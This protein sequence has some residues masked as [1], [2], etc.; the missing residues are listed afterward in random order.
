MSDS[1][2]LPVSDADLDGKERQYLLEAF[3]SGWISGSGKFVDRFEENFSEYIGSRHAISCANGTVALHLALL[4]LGIGPGDEVIVPALTYVSTANA[5]RYCGSDPVFADCD[6]ETWNVSIDTIE[7][8]IG[9][10]TRAIVVVHLYGNPVDMDPIMKLAAERG[11]PVVE[12]AAEAHGAEYRGQKVGSIGDIGTFS[13]YGNK[14]MT[15]G[16][17][18]MVVTNDEKLAQKISLLRGQGMDP[19]RRYWF[20]IVGYNYRL[21]NLQCAI[22]LAQLER[23]EDFIAARR[24]LSTRYLQQLEGLGAI[25]FQ[26]VQENALGVWWMFSIVLDN[27]GMRD[28]LAQRLAGEGIETRPLFFPLHMLPPYEHY[29]S[30]CPVS[31][32]IGLSGINLPTGGHV[33][34]SD[35]EKIVSIVQSTLRSNG[36][37]K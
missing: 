18:G 34:A 19:D 28:Q 16:E 32:Q 21:T 30:N 3:D 31:E 29:E 1:K 15:T 13:F 20:P 5:V 23:V 9:N 10:R 11:I 22:G 4:S 37:S 12:D 35:V 36:V 14:V 24:S 2:K 25:R 17:G 27:Q 26:T 7:P 8:L 33:T 6:P